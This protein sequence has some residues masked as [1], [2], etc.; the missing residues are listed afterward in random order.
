MI[1]ETAT[2]S[3]VIKNG[4]GEIYLDLISYFLAKNILLSIST[5]KGSA[6]L[7]YRKNYF[8]EPIML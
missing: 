4:P 1:G 7:L 3:A 5:A 6:H 8:R 2:V